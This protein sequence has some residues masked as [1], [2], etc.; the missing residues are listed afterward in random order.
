M[1]PELAITD[2]AAEAWEQRERSLFEAIFAPSPH[3]LPSELAERER[4]ISQGPRRGARWLNET[5]PYLVE[6][7]DFVATPWARRGVV[8]KSSRV[9][10]TEGV[11]G[12]VVLWTVV[13]DP[14]PIA[15]VQPSDGE[16]EA[17]SKEQISPMIDLNEGLS[18]RIG[19]MGVR[20]SDSTITY[21]EFLGGFLSILG[22]ASDRNMRRRSFR[23]MLVDEV[24]GMK[25]DSVEGDPLLRLQKRTDDFE[26]GVMLVGSTPTTKHL[27]RIDR[28]FGKTD[29]RFWHVPCP[30]CA[31]FQVLEWGGP[32]EDYGV[33]WDREI[34]CRGC[35]AEV[36][37]GASSCTSCNAEGSE[38][39]PAIPVT[40][41]HL[42]ETAHYV[43]RHC[44]ERIDESEKPA[45]VRAG[46]WIATKPDATTPGWHIDA[47]VSLFPGARWS[48]LAE[49]F[50]DAKDDPM[51]LQPWWNTV[52]GRAWEERGQKIEVSTLEARAE[53]YIDADGGL[54]EVPDG[55]GLLTAFVDVQG[56]W[57]ELLVR[58]W[59]LGEES[60]D[61]F[62]ERVTGDPEAAGTWARLESLLSRGY[63]HVNGR[64]LR[65]Q[66]AF[67]DAG[68]YT[69]TVYS[70]VKPREPRMIFASMGDKTGNPNHVPLARPS[71]ANAAGVRVYTLGTFKLK[72]MLF[73]RLSIQ[74]PGPRY[75][76]L[77]AYSPDLCNGFDAEY[78]AQA[79][80]EKRVN[81]RVKG[82]RQVK[83][84]YVQTRER[85]EFIDL[86]VGNFGALMALGASVRT[87]MP[88]WVEVARQPPPE[89]VPESAQA[90]E[91][92]ESS[93][94]Y[95]WRR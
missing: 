72:S 15:I 8:R 73:R 69:D 36:E 45:M 29:Q 64:A 23:R 86:H 91:P 47:L 40:V 10:Y 18:S 52:L 7:M 58:G 85:N 41:Q 4:I 65:I 83:P 44:H 79:E 24:D 53:Q 19:A 71:K 26:D 39:R 68:A 11:I 87:L 94:A 3:L 37:E 20:S 33:K 92:A 1:P 77:R 76:H 27:S 51:D 48:K 55:V 90:A 60:W 42:P 66:S 88:E 75:M 82:S 14:C 78:F 13:L 25:V 81:R 74:A 12:N 34:F 16:A 59:G 5:T 80:S 49:E 9:G 6:I 89:P 32:N 54:V 67:I 50:L 38:E 84:M 28:D 70:F 56:S 17:Y 95:G 22:S 46:R 43:C 93:W 57:L 63:R 2:L 62:H 61:I 35:G 21:K 31:E 30:H